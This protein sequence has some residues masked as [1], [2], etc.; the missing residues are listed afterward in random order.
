MG[1]YSIS[2]LRDFRPGNVEMPTTAITGHPYMQ[3]QCAALALFNR[4]G[5]GRK[6][7]I[8]DVLLRDMSAP[9]AV[10]IAAMDVVRISNYTGGDN[11]LTPDKHDPNNDSLP[12]TVVAF[13]DCDTVSVVGNAFRT[14]PVIPW[15]NES[16]SVLNRPGTLTPGNTREGMSTSNF[17]YQNFER[18][19]TIQGLILR[20]GEG[21]AV[22]PKA[23]AVYY[24]MKYK[25]IIKFR[26]TSNNH[27]YSLSDAVVLSGDRIPIVLFNGSG[28]GVIL[29]VYQIDIIDVGSST[30][31]SL[32]SVEKIDSCD[33]DHSALSVIAKLDPNNEDLTGLVDYR[34]EANVTLAGHKQGAIMVRPILKRDWQTSNGNANY[35]IPNFGGKNPRLFDHPPNP[36][37]NFI[38]NPG[39]GIA[40]FKRTISGIG[41][42]SIMMRFNVDPIGGYAKSRIVNN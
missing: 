5:S 21:V 12:A 13:E 19:T 33:R 18:V 42:N 32:F 29:E 34:V 20:E 36:D 1:T 2:S 11:A 23:N 6:V 17:F 30:F 3:D 40:V 26:K 16:Q 14:I 37:G 28:S 38:L 22:M 9:N 31:P 8:S 39:E 27:C 7:T 25:M 4:T 24:P 35:T 15:W 10:A 41:S